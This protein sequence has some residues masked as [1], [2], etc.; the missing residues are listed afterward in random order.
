MKKDKYGWLLI[1]LLGGM[2]LGRLTIPDEVWGAEPVITYMDGQTVKEDEV[3]PSLNQIEEAEDFLS[4]NQITVPEDIKGLCEK[5]G[6]KNNIAPELLEA[7]IFVESSY[8]ENIVDNS[9]TCKGLCQ[10]KP[11]AHSKRMKLLGVTD[12][13]DKEGNIAVGADY[14]RELFEKYEDVSVVL[15]MYNGDGRALEPGYI[16]DYARKVMK[17]SQAL[18]R[19][20]WR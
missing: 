2:I 17:I 13:F 11:A 12:I 20:N 7:L 1:G 10:I 16:S 4:F 3:Y 14:L 8:Q 5:Y 6:K 18:E 9:G 15:A 19:A